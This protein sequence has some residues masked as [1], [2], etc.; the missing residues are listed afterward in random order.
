MLLFNL[1]I[2]T[3]QILLP[4]TIIH[5]YYSTTQS[6]LKKNSF[7]NTDRLVCKNIDELFEQ[8]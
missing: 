8:L 5:V 1:I 6:V 3:M 4:F 2:C 7:N